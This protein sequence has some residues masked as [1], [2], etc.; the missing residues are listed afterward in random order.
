M[1]IAVTYDNGNVFQHF[2][3]TEAFKVYDIE[4]GKIKSSE[5]IPTNGSGH[6]ALAGFL[7][8]LG[9]STLELAAARKW[10]SLKLELNS[11]RVLLVAAMKQ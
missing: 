5:V 2:G 1:K 8:D 10:H 6:G 3:H 4:D 7:K 9:V 11:M